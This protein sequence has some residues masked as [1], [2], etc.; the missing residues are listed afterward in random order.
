MKDL[1]TEDQQERRGVGASQHLQH[2]TRNLVGLP[3]IRGSAHRYGECDVFLRGDASVFVYVIDDKHLVIPER[4]GNR[5][6]D[7]LGSQT[8]GP[9]QKIAESGQ[10]IGGS[11]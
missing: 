2:Y 4:P 10:N 3:S 6:M 7:S 1:R 11:R 8:H 5:R 9:V